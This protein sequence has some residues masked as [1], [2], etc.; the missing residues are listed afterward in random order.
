MKTIDLLQGIY[1]NGDIYTNKDFVDSLTDD[2]FIILVKSL[3]TLSFIFAKS[4]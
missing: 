2:K 3:K 4:V 1:Y